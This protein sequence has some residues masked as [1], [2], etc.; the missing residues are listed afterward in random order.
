M[1]NIMDVL[2]ADGIFPKKVSRAEFASF[3][4]ACGGE[5]RFRVWPEEDNGGR[6]WCRRCG[7]EGDVIGYFR[8]FKGLSYWEA[9][10]AAGREPKLYASS[11][12]SPNP[13]IQSRHE[14]E[15]KPKKVAD[16]PA[17]WME[18]AEQFVTHCAHDL[19]EEKH[20][21]QWLERERGLSL[22]T[23]TQLR[24]G[25]NPRH[26]VEDREAWGLPPKL[27]DDGK[28]KRL[29]APAGLVIPCR[30]WGRMMKIK[31]RSDH[32]G[33]RAAHRNFT[34]PKYFLLPGSSNACMV[35]T[36][37]GT[38]VVI[39]VESELDAILIQQDAGD[40][41]TVVAL[42]SAQARPDAYADFI[43]R[44]AQ[45]ILVALDVDDAGVKA[46]NEWW[47]RHYDRARRWPPVNGKDPCEMLKA[48]FGIRD[49]VEVGIERASQDGQA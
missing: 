35:L 11:P 27:K 45:T 44:Q 2:A 36:R 42:G 12:H 32:R 47:W 34:H 25:W 22:E 23:V 16:P 9:C 7:R 29:W 43:L 40:L 33:D 49:W 24:L 21:L 8:V 28:Q 19:A 30:Q 26:L 39:V 18:R 37:G 13:P 46:A 3:C 15:W 5:D 48:G 10:E 20:V 6:W 4:P 14:R 41:V 1:L 38:D 31:I 17:M